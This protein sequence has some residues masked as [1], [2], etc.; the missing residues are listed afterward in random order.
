MPANPERTFGMLLSEVSRLWRR[1]AM[2]RLAPLGL[3]EAQAKTL[4]HLSRNEGINQV[5]LADILEVQPITL[6]RTVD[7]LVEAG[8]VERRP[9]PRDR[10]AVRLYLTRAGKP[11]VEEMWRRA[12]GSREDAFAGLDEETRERLIDLFLTIKSNLL[13]AETDAVEKGTGTDD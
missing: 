12:A 13:A 6:G 2:R 11:M 3:T 4:A 5:C 8:L 7:K 9:D 1:N 10:R